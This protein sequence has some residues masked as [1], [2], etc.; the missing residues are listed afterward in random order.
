MLFTRWLRNLKAAWTRGPV[1]CGRMTADRRPSLR[2][3]PTLE[4]LERRDLLSAALVADIAHTPLSSNPSGGVVIGNTMYFSAYDGVHGYELWKSDG[5]TAGTVVVKNISAG[6][7]TN[8]NGTLFFTGSDTGT[9]AQLWKSDGT[10]AGT[11]RIKDL[12]AVSTP[13][14]NMTVAN[15]TLFFTVNNGLWKSDGTEAGTFLL[16]GASTG[17]FGGPQL[18]PVNGTLFFRNNSNVWKS[19]GTVAGTVLVKDLNSGG[20]GSYPY[21]L[22]NLNGV[23]IFS[24]VQ[25]HARSLWRSDGTDAGTV[26]IPV[27]DLLEPIFLSSYP[28]RPVVVNGDL[29]FTGA[30]SVH[31]EQLW[32]TDGTTAGTVLVKVIAPGFSSSEPINL[33]NVNGTIYFT[34]TD[35]VH[36]QE[37]WKSDGTAAG[38]M[39]VKDINPNPSNPA[40]SNLTNVN[41]TLYFTDNDGVHGQELWK[42]DGTAAGTM[43]V[44]DILPGLSGSSPINLTALNNTLL[45]SAD[46]AIHGRELWKSDGTADGTVLVMDI[47]PLVDVSP[48]SRPRYLTD[49]NGT[50]FFTATDTA[51]GSDL[52]KSDGTAAGTVLVKD[53]NSGTLFPRGLYP[54]NLTNVNGTLFF[55]ADDGVNGRELWKSDGT[56]AG[57]VMVKDIFPGTHLYSAFTSVPNESDP[58][59]LTN[60][61]GTLFFTADDG[62]HGREVWKS[63]GTAAGTVLVKDVNPAGAN[64]SNYPSELT[65]VNGTIFF[66]ADDGVHG[67]EL[68]KSDGSAVG[69]VLV[70]DINPGSSG[71][72]GYGLTN[73]NGTL[74]FTAYNGQPGADLWKSDGTA[75]GTVLVKDVNPGTALIQPVNLT[76][77]NGT[78]FFTQ[79][80][81]AGAELWKSDGTADGTVLV[82]NVYPGSP[83]VNGGVVA[84]Q[85]SLTNVNGTLFFAADDGVH[86]RQLWKSDGSAA[87]TVLVTDLSPGGDPRYLTNVNGTVFFSAYDGTPGY[88]DQAYQVWKSDGTAAGTKVV[89]D[90]P[91][92]NAFGQIP[93]HLTNVNGTLF[94]AA[95]DGVHGLELWR[96]SQV[97]QNDSAR[98]A[99]TTP[100]TVNVFANDFFSPGS[101][102]VVSVAQPAHGSASVTAN[103]ALTYTP[104]AGFNG[105]D[106]VTYTVVNRF[107][108]TDTATVSVT[109]YLEVNPATV[110]ARLQADVT[111]A[112]AATTPPGTPTVF[113]HVNH[114]SNMPKFVAAL[115][116]LTVKPGG[117][118]IDIVLD[119]GAG[120][121]N[122]GQ[123]SVPAGLRLVIDRPAGATFAAGSTPALKL[124]SGEVVLGDGALFTS[125]GDAPAIEVKGGQL[126]LGASTFTSSGDGSAILVEAGQLT[127]SNSTFTASGDDPVIQVKGGQVLLLGSTITSTGDGPAIEVKGGQLTVGAST[128]TASGDDPAIQVKGG[129]LTIRNST[130]EETSAGTQAAIAISGG[131]VDL[132]TDND[133][134]GNTISVH[135][136]GRLI[137]NTGPNDVSAVGNTFLQDGVGFADDYRIEDAIDHLMDGLG[138][139]TVFWISNNVFVSANH[140][141]VQRGVDLVPDGGFVNVETGVR[142]DFS[143]GAKLL[144]VAFQDGSAMTQQI[145]DLDPTLRTL[146]VTGTYGDDVIEFERASHDGV[147]VEMNHVPSGTFLPTGRLIA[148]GVD[149]S[150][151]ISVS[152]DIHLSAWLFGGYSGNNLLKGGGGN[153]VLVGGV[154]NDTLIAGTGRD[155]LIGDGGN[156]LLVGKSGED[157]LIGGYCA[158]AG[159]GGGVDETAV[160]ALMAEWTSGDN[161]AL[162]VNYLE[163][164]G[165]LNGTY[166]LTP[167]VTVFDDG[168]VNVLNG[169]AGRD[170]FFAGLTDTVKGLRANETVVPV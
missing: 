138:G 115:A 92:P 100:V 134:G 23:L 162:R 106:N 63:D 90:I 118:V 32:K 15:G 74:F 120:G 2:S 22:T 89:Q 5:T 170:L 128:F 10:E 53:F 119:V 44:K 79:Y 122:L 126:T 167:N 70:L 7:L 149:G 166:T 27:P 41:G 51:H 43:M 99:E 73:V 77:V 147:R 19:D 91:N 153:D 152:N 57:T 159:A 142:G 68:W 48:S 158:F 102:P 45:F 37:L 3:R 163:N 94:F 65:N 16:G 165:G 140:G 21:G 17:N 114:P 39:M 50:L 161:Y 156:D 71:S 88:Q 86:G 25:N 124:L 64:G 105:V 103:G 6:N 87:G 30:D 143:A 117:P 18:T 66:E 85:D 29:F 135:G 137:C 108:D 164:G 49:V 8:V 160:D 133:Q 139:G 112:V 146:V 62:L 98:T 121:Y 46:D 67:R 12:N 11:V 36:G 33:T 60:V 111:A 61:N 82:K 151:N 154:G 80:D 129:Q 132:G 168:A 58:R 24:A 109:V 155:L 123:V 38:T 81:A 145:D 110:A 104:A 157:I 26:R 78:L 54:T 1:S 4:C 40:P 96:S 150:D 97:L 59:D 101:Q 76:N 136:K 127:V 34:D 148:Y 169:G 55:S 14:V 28:V 130:I 9:G 131:V 93:F 113:V 52:W 83:T 125:S 13:P 116:N 20:F 141:S 69:T 47:N 35:G 75:A 31:G 56:D 107:G 144:T 42:S 95:D 84:T 72:A